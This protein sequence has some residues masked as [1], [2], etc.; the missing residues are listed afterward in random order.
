[1]R[2]PESAEADGNLPN[3]GID[4]LSASIRAFGSTSALVPPTVSI[5]KENGLSNLKCFG[6]G[7]SNQA[8]VKAFYIL[9]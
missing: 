8:I 3:G 2:R 6:I 4:G 1:M 5:S 7:D 9:Y